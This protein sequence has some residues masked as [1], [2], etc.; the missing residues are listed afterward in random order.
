[1]A[2]KEQKLPHQLDSRRLYSD[3]LATSLL[4]QTWI[5]APDLHFEFTIVVNHT[6]VTYLGFSNSI[7]GFQF[8]LW[9]T[10]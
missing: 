1:M 2:V 9:L 4:G 5:P 8:H 6:R 7:C 10:W 3:T